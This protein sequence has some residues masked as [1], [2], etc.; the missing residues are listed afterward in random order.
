M[1][2]I[3]VDHLQPGM[4]LAK[5]LMKGSM[6]VLGE[7]TVLTAT[8]ISRIEDMGVDQIFI[9]GPAEQP[10]P[11]EEAL[12]CLDERFRGVMDKPH[13]SDIKKLVKEHIVGLYAG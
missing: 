1:P 7:G 12:A 2:S 8:W 13:M 4:I 5:P 6:V 10:I 11:I 3:S 9:D